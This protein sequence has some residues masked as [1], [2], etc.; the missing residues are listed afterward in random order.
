MQYFFSQML[1]SEKGDWP[2]E[3]RWLGGPFTSAHRGKK[4]L[5]GKQ[6]HSTEHSG[7]PNT[8]KQCSQ[9]MQLGLSLF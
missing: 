4:R 8:G 1:G 7:K 6:N 9:N 3:K 2:Q 5:L